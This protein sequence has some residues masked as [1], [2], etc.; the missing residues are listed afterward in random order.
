V[1]VDRVGGLDRRRQGLF[2]SR[3]ITDDVGNN[4]RV[5]GGSYA[6]QHGLGGWSMK[7]PTDG[8]RTFGNGWHF[9]SLVSSIPSPFQTLVLPINPHKCISSGRADPAI[10]HRDVLQSTTI[11]AR[12]FC[13][14]GTL[15]RSAASIAGRS[16]LG[17]LRPDRIQD[18]RQPRAT[19]GELL[20]LDLIH[21][22]Q[23]RVVVVE[24]DHP[25]QSARAWRW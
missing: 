22:L 14:F 17:L 8:V 4:N 15:P 13:A 24:R 11:S 10:P 3:E 19:L 21:P 1:N 2:G 12:E 9:Q 7:T 25:M 20:A 23:I 5:F 18:L 16:C 6:R